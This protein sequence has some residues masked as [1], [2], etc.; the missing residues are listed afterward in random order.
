MTAPYKR[1][2][3]IINPAAGQPEPILNTLNTVFHPHD[4]DWD[5]SLTHKFGDARHLA[6]DAVAN[7]VDLVAGYGGDGTQME[8]AS[9]VMDSGTPLA[10]FP[11]GTGNA[12][13]YELNIP[14]N[15]KAAAELICQ[16]PSL[17]K[18]D[19]A[20][21]GERYFMLRTYTGLDT[22]KAASREMKDHFGQLAYVGASLK[23]LRETPTAHYR[24]T[25]DGEL[26]EGEAMIC[27]ILNAGALGGVLGMPLPGIAKVDVSDGLLD[28]Y[29]ITAGLKPLR[30]VSRIMLQVGEA[31]A[32][33][34]HWQGREISLEAD[35][36]QNVWID[37]EEYGPTPITATVIPQ[38]VKVVVPA[39]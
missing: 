16:N 22:E 38:A 23:F 3:I 8:I 11:G 2:H 21:I 33:V 13:T 34:Y 4:I 1:I 29:A 25:V 26:I 30:A 24:A 10:I 32:G 37:G 20:R 35:P 9:G 39:V 19:V 27:F 5:I 15:L 12:M 14:H 6:R 31:Q 28:L 36:P 17:R 7:G 18:I